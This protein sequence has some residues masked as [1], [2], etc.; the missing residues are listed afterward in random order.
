MM[1][2]YIGITNPVQLVN[3]KLYKCLGKEYEFYRVIDESGEDYLYLAEDFEIIEP[4]PAQEEND[5]QYIYRDKGV[6]VGEAIPQKRKVLHFLKAFRPTSATSGKVFDVVSQ[7]SVDNLY[8]V[9]Y[10]YC[11]FFW[12]ETDIYHFEKYNMPLNQSFLNF[13]LTKTSNI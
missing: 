7:Q 9:C 1:V 5:I 6:Y 8:N 13:V 4:N 10:E 11:G 2:K 3:G 12:S